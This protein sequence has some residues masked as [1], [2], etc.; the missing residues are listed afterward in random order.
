M[1]GGDLLSL[2]FWCLEAGSVAL[3]LVLARCF[4]VGMQRF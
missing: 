4:D 1:A 2:F 3:L